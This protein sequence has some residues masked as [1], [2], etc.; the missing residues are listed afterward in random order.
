[1]NSALALL[2]GEKTRT[3]PF[4]V[5]P[6]IGQEEKDLVLEVLNQGQLSGFVAQPGAAF[7]GGT[8]VRQLEQMFVDY[9]GARFAVAVNSA[10]AGLH[11]ALAA[12]GIREGDEVIV[13]P[14]T[15]SATAAAILMQRAKPIFADIDPITF[16]I[17]PKDIEK[18]ITPKT[19][20]LM[21]VHLFG[22]PADMDPILALAKKFKL[23]VVEDCAQSPGAIYKGKRVGTL[24]DVG[25]FSFNQHKIITTGEGGVAITQNETLALRMQLVRNH[26]EVVTGK[27][28][29]IHD[30]IIGWNYRMTEL[31][32]A[33]GI[34]QF[35]RLDSLTQQRI[36]LADYL[37]SKLS[38]IEGLMV[39][40]AI[41]DCKHV[42]FTYPFK[43]DEKLLGIDRAT[44]LKALLA[45][46]IPC[47]G[48]Y[49]RPI[50]YEPI[51]KKLCP[52][53]HCPVAE[54]MHF[55]ELC[56][57]PICR[58]PH[59]QQDMDDA[60]SAIKKILSN[61]SHLKNYA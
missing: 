58:H 33:I 38:S 7:L 5:H 43:L 52:N 11:A 16:C 8:K 18:K 47:A 19:K 36:H 31:E 1:M 61:L 25:I 24:G 39:P 44:F 21:V 3:Q 26:G 15:M 28:E 13:P 51:F 34:P 10:T 50:Y 30:D 55:K 6:F 23:A 42:Y 35:A 40:G 60:I 29:V 32:A 27:M 56:L 45:E 46:G 9:F 2:G 59:T 53:A 14:Y 17:D 37:S 22:A 48:G 20:A 49:V 4:A 54:R 41:K 57:L 12:L